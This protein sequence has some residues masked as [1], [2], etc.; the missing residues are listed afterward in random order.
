METLVLTAHASLLPH[1]HPHDAVSLVA[2]DSTL[3]TIV[4]ALAVLTA[5][6]LVWMAMTRRS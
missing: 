2:A 4:M 1:T 6:G 5:I 3:M